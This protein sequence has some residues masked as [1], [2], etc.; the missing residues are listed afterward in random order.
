[1]KP[2]ILYHG[3]SK[4]ISLLVPR[5][6]SK[7]LSNNSMKAVFAT[8]VKDRALAMGLTKT[9]GS[10]SFRGNKKMNFVKGSPRMKHV[11]LHYLGSKSFKQNRPGEFIS[12]IPVKPVKI[13]EYNVKNLSHLWRKS[14]MKELKEFLKNREK[15]R[16]ENKQK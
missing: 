9:K 2:K 11:Y 10:L 14:N 5:Q 8:N 6:P 1:M 4:K 16:K 12:Y 7:D 13:E 3:S 15:W